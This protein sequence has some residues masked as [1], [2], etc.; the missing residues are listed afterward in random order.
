MKKIL[1]IHVF[2][3]RPLID[4]NQCFRYIS[5]VKFLFLISNIVIRPFCEFDLLK[6]T[7]KLN[8]WMCTLF[9]H[10]NL[11]N[12]LWG[13]NFSF[14]NI[15]EKIS[16]DINHRVFEIWIFLSVVIGSLAFLMAIID[17]YFHIYLNVRGKF[18]S[19]DVKQYILYWEFKQQ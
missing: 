11:Y 19:K 13:K 4:K 15:I 17:S 12:T 16:N 18:F 2:S 9:M 10:E 5:C 14:F 7:T 8:L 3:I 6:I 1:Y